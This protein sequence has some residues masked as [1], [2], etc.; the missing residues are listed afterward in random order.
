MWLAWVKLSYNA[1]DQTTIRVTDFDLLYGCPAPS[2][3]YEKGSSPVNE[4][5]HLLKE[6]DVML[7]VLKKNLIKAK[8]RMLKYASSR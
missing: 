3:P 1:A 7:T 2:I 8:Q 4:I 6:R 5:D